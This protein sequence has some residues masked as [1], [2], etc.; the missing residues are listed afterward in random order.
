MTRQRRLIL[1]ILDAADTPLTADEIADHADARQANLALSTVY[2]SLDRLCASEVVSRLHFQDGIARFERRHRHHHHYL[3]CT[4]C[5]ACQ[6]IDE[7]PMQQ[8]QADLEAS[9]GYL[10][11]GHQLNVF[12]LCPSCRSQ[13]GQTGPA[14]PARPGGPD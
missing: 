7:C 10:V 6:I 5:Q 14:S 11:T 12:G 1:T 13:A 4:R 9:T 2:R 3:I 8:L